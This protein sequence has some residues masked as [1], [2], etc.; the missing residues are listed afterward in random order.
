VALFQNNRVVM[1]PLGKKGVNYRSHKEQA[2]PE[3]ERL[4]TDSVAKNTKQTG[5]PR[6]AV[7]FES[8]GEGS[9]DWWRRR[10][11]SSSSK[12][13]QDEAQQDGN[14]FSAV[15]KPLQSRK[16]YHF[17]REDPDDPARFSTSIRRISSIASGF[18]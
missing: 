3:I 12:C 17:S 4:Y 9:G 2:A 14:I 11:N 18:N 1:K 16:N 13:H 15:D 7:C 5:R 8:R 10:M 6:I